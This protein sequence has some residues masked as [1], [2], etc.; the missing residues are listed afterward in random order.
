MPTQTIG[1]IKVVV[2]NQDT[3]SLSVRQSNQFDSKV[4]SLSYGQPLLLKKA[5]DLSIVTPQD[6]EAITYDANTGN[7]AVTPVTA[8]N[9][10]YANTANT[11]LLVR[12]GTF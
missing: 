3:G 9:A 12:G 10:I 1:N 4:R 6:G 7:F 2:N 8:N 11:V 5:I